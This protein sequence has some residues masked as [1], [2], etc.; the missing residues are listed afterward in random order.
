MAGSEEPF[1]DVFY[2]KDYFCVEVVCIL[3]GEA[4]V[5]F[6]VGDM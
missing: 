5:V 3:M 1:G 2:Y 6:C 4:N